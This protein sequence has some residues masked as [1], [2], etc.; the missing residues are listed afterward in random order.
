MLLLHPFFCCIVE[1]ETVIENKSYERI[2]LGRVPVQRPLRK[3]VGRQTKIAQG[4]DSI[5]PADGAMA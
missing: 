2:V 5:T 3:S 4:H 1:S